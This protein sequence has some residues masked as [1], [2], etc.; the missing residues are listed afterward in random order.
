MRARY[1][2]T[3]CAVIVLAGSFSM[4]AQQQLPSSAASPTRPQPDAEFLQ[5]ADEVLAEMS[6]LLALPVREPLKKSIR[7]KDQ[8]RQY[9]I[10][11][12]HEQEDSG[13]RHADQRMLEAL[14]LLPKGYPL[15]QKL[16][17]MLTNEI[18]GVY[19]PKE[20]EFFIATSVN[21][22]EQRM[23][24]AHELTH[25]LQ[26]QYF[27]IQQWSKAAKNN[28][29]ASFAREAVLEGSA[30]IAM[31]AYLLRD[32]TPSFRD[33]ASFDPSLLMGDL[34]GSAEMKDVPLVL[35]DQLLF[36]YLAG[37]KFS[38]K[39]LEASGGWP[40]LRRI[41]EHPPV[42]TQQ[43]LHPEL[44][45][46]G[47]QPESVRLPELKGLVPPGW[48]KLDEN[49][50]GEFGFHQIFKQFLGN[51]RADQ[52]A[53]SW[54]GDR[55]AIFE[56]SPEGRTLMLIRVR[57]A[58]EPATSAFFAGYSELLQHKY[59]SRSS[60]V[61]QAQLFSFETPQ[62]GGVAIRCQIRECLL[63]EGATRAQFERLTGLLGWPRLASP[64]T[65]ESQTARAVHAPLA[66]VFPATRGYPAQLDAN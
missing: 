5:A 9:L 58:A 10:R 20:R 2:A 18:A 65:L 28:D 4:L 34:D 57:L 55:Y 42:S 52:L 1:C 26:D 59:S 8:I 7:N 31:L 51:E 62:A 33:F 46:R 14:G 43:I 49:I 56:Q 16:I 41:F 17:E 32:A 66:P 38:A 44:Y 12:M 19:D 30:M 29:D 36:P 61:R 21:P 53:A 48:K 64:A 11:A 45:L 13:K 40:G 15:E 35:R 47:V 24:M 39:V 25:A 27:H 6:K 37:A 50:I 23:V 63:A 60:V 22:A 54:S 3:L